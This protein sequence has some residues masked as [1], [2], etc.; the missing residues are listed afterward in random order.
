MEW[1]I[2]AIPDSASI[3]YATLMYE[4]STLAGA[5]NCAINSMGNRPSTTTNGTALWNDIGDGTNYVGNDNFCTYT[6]NK[7]VPLGTNAAN[8]L[9]ASLGSNWFSIGI[10]VSNETRDS[11]G[12]SSSFHLSEASSTHL[13]P[14]L[15]VF[16]MTNSDVD[17]QAYGAVYG[18]TT[19]AADAP[20]YR[21]WQP[22]L[23]SWSSEVI[24]PATGS[25]MRNVWI[26]YSPTSIDTILAMTESGDGTL[27]LF[28][29]TATCTTGS[30]WNLVSSDFAD[31]GSPTSPNT[32]AGMKFEQSSG[33]LLIVYD[34][35]ALLHLR[36]LQVCETIG[37]IRQRNSTRKFVKSAIKRLHYLIKE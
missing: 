14:T 12:H 25:N 27:N 13:D 24:L 26:E 6:G 21:Q 5:R 16:Y 36:V 28:K 18:T 35:W 17:L 29:C 20:R 34:K 9:G 3:K 11:G 8:D 37:S 22:S 15:Q 31:V 23:F 1:N 4:Q 30:N 10:K 33:D 19:F 7:A 2:T 32:Y